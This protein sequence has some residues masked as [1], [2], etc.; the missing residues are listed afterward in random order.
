MVTRNEK[1][2][3]NQKLSKRA[4]CMNR[5]RYQNQPMEKFKG[6]KVSMWPD[7][8]NLSILK[9]ELFNVLR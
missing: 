6:K 5:S 7:M 9:S 2:K 4:G 1:T 3:L 8:S